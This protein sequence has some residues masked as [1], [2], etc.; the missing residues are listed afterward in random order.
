LKDFIESPANLKELEYILSNSG[1]TWAQFLAATSIKNLLCDNWSKI[2]NEE[3]VSIKDFCLG[4]LVNK[5][6][7][8]DKN[9]MKMILQLMA[10]ICKLSWLDNVELKSLVSEIS[11]LFNVRI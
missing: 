9:V 6:L 8:S 3:K 2:S 10:K 1:N 5:A 11:Q 4:Y 7:H